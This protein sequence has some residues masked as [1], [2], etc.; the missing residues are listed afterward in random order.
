MTAMLP[1]VPEW[2]IFATTGPLGERTFYLQCSEGATVYTY[3]MEKQQVMVLAGRLG[4]LLKDAPRP[5]HLPD[6]D[7]LFLQPFNE[8]NFI[9][10][11]MAVAYD[12]NLDRVVLI[13]EDI[14]SSLDEFEEFDEYTNLPDVDTLAEMIDGARASQ[15]LLTREQA[16]ALSIAGITISKAGRPPCPLCGYPL[17]PRGHACPRTNGHKPPRR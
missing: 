12:S 11:T 17:D 14:E 10:G 2:V 6:V 9:V 1:I 3:K 15:L 8:V 4:E 7:N 13:L 5:G 16:A